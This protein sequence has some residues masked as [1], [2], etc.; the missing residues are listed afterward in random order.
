[1]ELRLV[2][3][4]IVV[5]SICLSVRAQQTAASASENQQGPPG[6]TTRD[7]RT[8]EYTNSKY[9]FS[10]TLPASWKGYRIIWSTWQGHLPGDGGTI[11]GPALQIR[12]PRWT[13]ENPREDIPIMIYS[14]AQWKANPIVSAAPIDP[15]ELGRNRKYVFALP[16]RWDFDELEGV[17]EAETIVSHNPLRTFAPQDGVLKL[18]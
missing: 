9:G 12:H 1:M 15:N 2:V 14:I 16:P 5:M 13:A 6:A 10:V 11:H 7:E 8:I 3:L 4:T 18:R 17:E